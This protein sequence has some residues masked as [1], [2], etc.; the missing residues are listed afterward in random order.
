VFLL[1]APALGMLTGA[2]H[3]KTVSSGAPPVELET[4][5]RQCLDEGRKALERGKQAE[6]ISIFEKCA[7]RYPKSGPA[8]YWLGCAYLDADKTVEA[9]RALKAAVRLS[10]EDWNAVHMLGRTYALDDTKLDIA[11]D[12]LEK[13]LSM[14]PIDNQVKLDLARVYALQGA[15]E[16]AFNLFGEILDTERDY[17]IYHTELGKLLTA[18]CQHDAARK[19][20]E[21]A[22]L[23][24][25]DYQPAKKGLEDL[26]KKIKEK[27]LWKGAPGTK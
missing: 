15:Y 12:L 6:A 26:E 9:A 3:A 16:P 27:A 19:E 23:L 4:L 5:I 24:F 11:K 8:H 21:R 13:A 20:F 7:E 14:N 2:T 1:A 18:I 25:P 22:L 17:A 10:P